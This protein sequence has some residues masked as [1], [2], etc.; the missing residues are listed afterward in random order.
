[1]VF[2]QS[3]G[4]KKNKTNQNQHANTVKTRGT[5]S[6]TAGH[7][8]PKTK[9]DKENGTKKN[10]HSANTNITYCLTWRRNL[11]YLYLKKTSELFPESTNGESQSINQE[12]HT[13]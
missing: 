2:K 11:A 10:L 9:H 7:Y 13:R 4:G 1:M 8:N 3:Q 12:F 5:Q 6:Q